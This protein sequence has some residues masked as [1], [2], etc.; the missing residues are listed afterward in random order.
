M[1]WNLSEYD[2]IIDISEVIH[3]TK[4]LSKKLKRKIYIQFKDHINFITVYKNIQYLT[5]HPYHLS[6]CRKGLCHLQL[7]V[8]H[9]CRPTVMSKRFWE[10]F[11]L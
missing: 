2:E 1:H 10:G 9:L 8:H 6:L 11:L 3:N 4:W 5:V 7:E